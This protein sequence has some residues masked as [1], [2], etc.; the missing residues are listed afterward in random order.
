MRHRFWCIHR[1]CTPATTCEARA[2]IQKCESETST[3][4]IIFAHTARNLFSEANV[5]EIR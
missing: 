4:S 1:N 2:E 5:E 3:L